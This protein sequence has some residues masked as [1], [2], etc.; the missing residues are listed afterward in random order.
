MSD[1]RPNGGPRGASRT[2][3]ANSTVVDPGSV[4][5][6]V[7]TD[8]GELKTGDKILNDSGGK[9]RTGTATAP[10]LTRARSRRSTVNAPPPPAMRRA[11]TAG[12]LFR[13]PSGAPTV[14][15]FRSVGMSEKEIYGDTPAELIKL[16]RIRT[17]ETVASLYR[18]ITVDEGEMSA[19]NDGQEL[20]EI[21]PELVTWDGPEDPENPRNWVRSKKWRATIAMAAYSFLGPLSSSIVSPAVPK[22]CMSFGVTNTT[23]AALIV[24]IF[25]LAWAITPLIV[26]PLSEMFGRRV[27][28]HVSI[29]V[30]LVFN[31]A[32]GLAKDLAQMI[33]FRFLAGAGGAGP[34][35]IG[36]GVVAD[37]WNDD[38]RTAAIGLFSIGPTLGPV[39]APIIAGW[40]AM[41]LEWQWVFWILI[42]LNGV[43]FA[44]GLL[45]LEETY[46]P[47]LLQWKARKLRKE[48]QNPALH[49][50]FEIT[51]YTAI[52]RLEIA[53]SRP[54]VLL[55]TNPLVF[56]L[57]LYLAFT[58][59]FLYLLL[60]T[61]PSLW[62]VDYGFSVG[63]SGLMYLGPGIGFFIGIMAVTS[64]SQRVYHRLVVQNGG[65]A[66]PEFRLPALAIGAVCMPVGLIWYGWSAEKHIFWIMPLIGTALFGISLIAV[67][68]CIQSYLIDMNPSYA[69]S[70][71]AA[72]ATF[73]SL[74]GFAFPLFASQMYAKLGRGWGNTLLGFVALVIGTVFP[75]VVYY[76]GEKIR[77][78]NDKRMD[79][80]KAREQARREE[81]IS[82]RLE[83]EA[84]AQEDKLGPDTP[85]VIETRQIHGI[86]EE[87]ASEDGSMKGQ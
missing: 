48:T 14:N 70:S 1:I 59:G 36:A 17:M 7:A 43:V 53:V 26:A 24:S 4:N 47:V 58:Y 25:V 16:E 66:K 42:I 19:P 38:E 32:C 67:F 46:A 52:E 28:L 45:T 57:G 15:S 11:N 72:G 51:N 3:S 62:E 22:I 12:V 55:F 86:P 18:T 81:R 5:V 27:V 33:V 82:R 23:V 63:I 64:V 34:L 87:E 31:M 65:V 21:D 84:L 49:T 41:N 61:F 78:W 68:A 75:A 29:F 50:V 71:T 39:V 44:F 8:D 6:S 54:I 60:V 2:S 40:I 73:R 35:A 83:Q 69:A 80:R 85:A 13:R 76:K 77:Q 9:V 30:L 79:A 74:F 20:V 37:I 56:G 10:A